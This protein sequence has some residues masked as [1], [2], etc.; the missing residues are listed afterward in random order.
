VGIQDLPALNATLNGLAAV[1]LT[2]GYVFIRR[3]RQQ[4]HE[5]CMLAALSTSTLFL[6]SYVVYHANVGSRPFEGQGAVRVVY[7]TILLTHVVLAAL[8]V[9]LA[10]V[11]ARRGLRRRLDAHVRLAR[12]TLPVWLYVSVTGVA[13]YVMLYW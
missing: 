12:W 3:G 11:T 9:P 10:L 7:F 1:F 2:L 8:V 6:I 13:I 5:R 4:A